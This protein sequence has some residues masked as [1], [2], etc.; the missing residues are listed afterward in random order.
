MDKWLKLYDALTGNLKLLG[1]AI[2]VLLGLIF[3]IFGLIKTIFFVL[4]VI[5]G[6]YVGKKLEEREDWRDVIEKIMPDK[7][8]D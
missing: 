3:L 5:G 7:S 4:F 8:R 1:T 2:G 6:F